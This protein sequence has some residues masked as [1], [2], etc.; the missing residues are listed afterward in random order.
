[1][2]Q[3]VNPPY[4]YIRVFNK[5]G[6]NGDNTSDE[7]PLVNRDKGDG[8]HEVQN[9]VVCFAESNKGCDISYVYDFRYVDMETEKNVLWRK[10]I[11]FKEGIPSGSYCD[12]VEKVYYGNNRNFWQ[13]YFTHAGTNYKINKNNAEFNLSQTKD[14]EKLVTI[15]IMPGCS[16]VNFTAPSGGAYFNVGK[17]DRIG[18]GIL[19]SV[20]NKLQQEVSGVRILY[21]ESDQTGISI[22]TE[23]PWRDILQCQDQKLQQQSSIK[24]ENRSKFYYHNSYWQLFFTYRNSCYAF[25]KTII[26]F[27]LLY[28]HNGKDLFITIQEKDNQ[29]HATFKILSKEK[30]NEMK[31]CG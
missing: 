28:E 27:N 9:V 31:V 29:C 3:K 2:R 23:L 14:K 13:V 24:S 1:M 26:D 25:Q 6:C 11:E 15:D 10:T 16:R 4:C 12:S 21:A 20:Q 30:N 18:R 8:T 5:L 7:I 22:E 19:V 17:G